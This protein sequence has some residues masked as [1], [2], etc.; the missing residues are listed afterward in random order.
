[1]RTSS[2]IATFM[3]GTNKYFDY[4]NTSDH[5][6]SGLISDPGLPALK[7]ERVSHPLVKQPKLAEMFVDYGDGISWFAWCDYDAN[8]V[9]INFNEDDELDF[10]S[11]F[12][13]GED[14]EG[15]IHLIEE[16][17]GFGFSSNK[18]VCG[19]D[20]EIKNVDQVKAEGR[21]CL[22]CLNKH[23]GLTN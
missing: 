7:M 8:Q 10:K 17:S 14:S 20:G 18:S 9:L 13:I 11:S 2:G 16:V 21:L 3:D 19:F 23:L 12:S 5:V 4:Q 1:M 15:V 22:E 6:I